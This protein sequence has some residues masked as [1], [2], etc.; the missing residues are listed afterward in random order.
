MP[1]SMISYV[2]QVMLNHVTVLDSHW[3]WLTGYFA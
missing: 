1:Y 3:S 2:Q